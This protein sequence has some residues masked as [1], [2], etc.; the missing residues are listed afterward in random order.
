MPEEDVDKRVNALKNEHDLHEIG[1]GELS[2]I[3]AAVWDKEVLGS[4]ELSNI[5]AAVW[6]KEVLGSG[7]LSNIYA[8]VWD[9]KVLGVDQ[10]K[11]GEELAELFDDCEVADNIPKQKKIKVRSQP[12]SP[13]FQG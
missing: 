8:A 2:N 13:Q 12:L 5:Y 10:R 9:K 7:D 3:Y 6:D 1:C 4:G 11:Y